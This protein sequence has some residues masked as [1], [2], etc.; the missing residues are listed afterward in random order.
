MKA[1]KFTWLMAKMLFF[2]IVGFNLV[3]G[4]FIAIAYFRGKLLQ[5]GDWMTHYAVGF[6]VGVVILFAYFIHSITKQDLPY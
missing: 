2:L 3:P 4:I 5:P 1:L 6:S